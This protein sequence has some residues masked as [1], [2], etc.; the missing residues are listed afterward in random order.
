VQTNIATINN[1]TAG[2]DLSGQ[3]Y[4]YSGGV[5]DG[6][7][8]QTAAVTL[9]NTNS[10]VSVTIPGYG[11]NWANSNLLAYGIYGSSNCTLRFSRNYGY[12]ARII[13]YTV[14]GG[15]STTNYTAK[16]NGVNMTLSSGTV[17]IPDGKTN[18]DIS[19]SAINPLQNASNNITVTLTSGY[20]KINS[21][22]KTVSIGLMPDYPTVDVTA[23][24]L[25]MIR[26]D[27]TSSLIFY[28]ELYFTN[29]G[30]ART[31]HYTLA[32]S[33]CANDGSDFT[34]ILTNSVV[35]PAGASAVT[36]VLV[37]TVQ[38]Y[39]N[40]TKN[41]IVTLTSSS[42]YNIGGTNTV[43]I[44][45]EDDFPNVEVGASFTTM[46]RG[47][48][49]TSLIFQRDTWYPGISPALTVNY[50]LAGSTAI[51]GTDYTA[52]WPITSGSAYIPA[53]VNSVTYGLT[54]AAEAS[55]GGTKTLT[56][57]L[58]P[59][60][61]YNYGAS[62][63]YTVGI[64]EDAPL[65]I[66]SAS[67]PYAYQNVSNGMFSIS[68]TGGLPNSATAHYTVSG[69]AVAGINYTNL[70]SSVTFSPN[71]TTTN[72]TVGP[73]ASPL[74]TNAQ[75][76][77]LSL[78]SNSQYYLGATT[79]AVVTILPVSSSTNSVASPVGRY[80][81]GTGDDPTFWSIV[82]PQ[83]YEKGV[84]YDNENGNCST[85]YPN[86]TSWSTTNY[87]HY[88]ATNT[89]TQSNSANRIQFNN[90]IVAFG[91]RVGGTPLYLNQNYSFGIYAGDQEGSPIVINV[92]T[93]SNYSYV[94]AIN[95]SVPTNYTNLSQAFISNGFQATFTNYGLT[96]TL[97]TTPD[98]NWGE[99]DAGEEISAYVLT[100]SAS[101]AATNYYYV[102]QSVGWPEDFS[103]P[104][105]QD[106]NGT[107]SPSILYSL[108][109]EPYP[110][111]RATFIDQPHFDGNP[112]PP[113]YA[114]M[115]V[116]EMLTNTPPV[117]NAVSLAPS[118]CTNL[119]DS[120]ELRRHP[121]LDQ[122][123]ANLGN[124][125]IALANYVI[126]QID[127]TDAMDYNDNGNV[128][129]QSINLSG[130]TRGALGTYLEKQGS[131]L[132]QCAL[133]V[134][135]LRQAG[136]PAAYEY[137]PHNGLQILDARLSRMLKFQVQGGFSEAGQ[138]YTSNTM[139]AVNYP[140]VAAYIGTNWV[141]IFPWLK[142]YD[143]EEGFNLWDYMPAN[144]PNAYAW[145]HDYIYGNT[146]LLSLAVDGDNTPRVVFP[147][148]LKQTLLQNHPTISVSDIG[149]KVL[150]RQHYYARWS[151]FPTPTSLTNI[152]YTVESM[153][154]S[155]I[156][157]VDPLL[158]NVFDTLNI[159]V[160]SLTDPHKDIQTGPM[161]L[162]DLHNRQFY[163]TQTNNAPN[164]WQLNLILAP[165]RTNV[166]TQYAYTNDAALLSKEVLTTT[167]DQ[168][169]DQLRVRFQY[170]RH[171]AL[172]PSY[173]IDPWLPFMGFSAGEQ[174]IFER[175]L[176][177]GDLAAICLDY[178]RVT[179]DMLN[180][181]AQDIWQM[182]NKLRINPAL[183]NSISSDVYQGATMYLAG[184]S[185]FEKLSE[186]DV[187][188]AN[189]NKVV[190]LSTWA[191]G[192]S[193]LS[194]HR[195][196][197][198]NLY[199]GGVDPILPNVDMFLYW[200]AR[201]GNGTLRPD[202]GQ[203]MEEVFHNYAVMSIVDGSAQEHQVINTYY[204]QTNAVST[205]RLLQLSQ[206]Q[207]RGIV[208]FNYYNYAA[209]GTNLYQGKQLQSIDTGLWQQV[210]NAFQS[211]YGPWITGYITPGPITNAAYS[212][213]GVFIFEWSQWLALI[214]PQSLNGAFGENMP[215]GTISGG[216][217]PNYNL[218]MGDGSTPV[219]ALQP[220]AAGSDVLPD[221]VAIFNAPQTY[222]E[223]LNGTYTFDPVNMT[224]DNFVNTLLGLTPKS[225]PA[226]TTAQALSYIWDVGSLGNTS[227]AGA[228][229]LT[230]ASDP[231]NTI[232]GEFYVDETDLQLPGPIPLSLRRNYSSQNLADNQFGTGWKLS[233]MPYLSVGVGATNIYAADMDGAVLAYVQTSTNTWMPT[234]VA[235]P[236]L[237]NNTTA[238]VGGLVNRLRDRLVQTVNAGVTNYTLYGA[239]GSTRTFLVT[240][241]NDGVIN[242]VRPYL[243]QWTD[244]AGN[245]YTFTYE[246]DP[247]E[248]D[249][250][251]V[252]R[253][254]CSN[255]NY[256]GF[257]YDIYGHILDAYC[258]DGRWLYY[259]YNE[260]G[261]LTAV[262]LPDNTV[263]EYKYLLGTQAV[264]NGS[265][266]SQQPYS[267]HLLIEEDKPEGRVLQNAYD[268]QQ[269][270]TNQ[271]STT[272]SDLN[273]VRTATF[274]Y[275]NNF[276]LTNSPTNAITGTTWIV[277]GLNHTNRYDYANNLITLVTDP[278]GQTFQQIWCADNA[279]APG[280]PRS[281][282]QRKDKRGVW[283]QF[284]YD[285]NGNVTNSA[286]TGDLTGDGIP[287]Q[288]AISTAIYNTN[289]LPLQ[290][291]DPVGNSMVYVYDANFPFKPQ[292]V[293]RYAGATPVSTNFQVYS[294]VTNT[295]ILGFTTQTNMA[296]GVMT[297]QIRAYGS[298]DAATNDFTYDGHGFITQ[299]VR[300]TGTTDPNIVN[301]YFYNERGN[302]VVQMDSLGAYTFMEYDALDRPIEKE[303]FDESGHPLAW[304]LTYY[305][306]NGEISWTDG[307]RYNPEDYIFYDYD[308]AGRVT[309]ELHW[310]SQAKSDGTGVEAP[311]G[312]NLY[313]Q[314]FYQYD[315][316][317]NLLLKV[318]PRGA[319]ATNIWDA[320]SRLV[321]TKHLDVDSATVLSTEGYSYEPGGQVQTH[322]NALGGVATTFYTATGKPEIRYNADGSTNGWRYY[323]DG[324][325]NLEIQRNGAYWQTTYDD[326]NRITTRTFY[327]PTG[328]P[329]AANSTQLD[330]RGNVIQ[331]V[332]AGGNVFTNAFD[333]L[334]RPKVTAGPAIVTV[335][336]VLSGMNPGGPV[337]YETNVLQEAVTNFYDSA[338]RAVTN[339]NALGEQTITTMDALGR[340]TGNFV[341]SASASL[342]REKYFA[343][344]A[345]HNSV[346]VTDG[347]GPTA[348]KHT[349]Y[350]DND[351]HTV[352]SIAYPYT[353]CLDYTWRSYDLSGNLAYEEHDTSPGGEFTFAGYAHDGLN[354]VTS[355]TNRD[356]AVTFYTH[357][358]L[359]DL[360]SR[361]IPGGLQWKA[362]YNNAGQVQADW[363]AGSG[364][365]T[366]RSNS[367]TYY[368]G[369]NAFA[370]LR[371]TMT[372]GRGMVSTYSYDDWLRQASI[373]R[374]DLDYNH[375]DTFWTYDPRGYATNILEQNTGWVLGNGGNNPKVVSRAYDPYGQLSSETVTWNGRTVSTASQ[376]WDAAGRRTGLSLNDANYGYGWRAD[377]AMTYA[378]D[379][380][381]SGN[382]G[383]D[384]A[385]LLTNRVVGSRTTTVNDRDGEGRPYAITT[386]VNGANQLIELMEWY[387]DGK[388][389][390]D[391]YYEPTL[392]AGW[393]YS[394][395]ARSR[396]LTQ[397]EFSIEY[398]NF[399][400]TDWTDWLTYDNGV[401]AGPG[402]LTQ[403][404]DPNQNC[405]NWNGGVSPF[406]RVNTETNTSTGYS[407][408]G[409]VN[410]Q[411]SLTALLDGQ[412]VAVTTTGTNDAYAWSAQMQ[413]TPGTHQLVVKALNWSGFY[414]ASATS[415]FTNKMGYETAAITRDYDGNIIQRTW[416]DTNGTMLH[417]QKLYFDVKNHLTDIIDADGANNGFVWH[418]EYDGLDRR[419]V[420]EYYVMTN[421][422]I[423]ITPQTIYQY[424]D[425]NVEFLE[426][427]VSVDN[428]TTWK[429]YGPDL[430][431][432]Y[433][434]LNGTGGLDGVS[435]YLNEFN[436]V[437]S[438]SRGNILAEVTNGIVSW[439]SAR[440]TGYGF[441][442]GYQPIALGHG[443]DLAQA[444]AWR[445]RW[446][447]ATGHYQ[448]G[449]RPY[450]PVAGN[451]LSYDSIFD[452]RDPNGLSAFGGDPINYFDADG[453]CPEGQ[454]QSA[455]WQTYGGPIGNETLADVAARLGLSGGLAATPWAIANA[456]GNVGMFTPNISYAT[457]PTDSG[458]GGQ[459]FMD[460]AVNLGAMQQD[461]SYLGNSDFR[462]GWG[463]AIGVT[464]GVKLGA[465]V[466]GA[467]GNIV[468]IG[469][470]GA[471]KTGIQ[472]GLT[473]LT[474]TGVKSLTEAGATATAN[475]SFYSAAYEMA[476]DA[477]DLGKSRPVQFNRANAALDAAMQ[478]DSEFAAQMEELIPGVGDS[479]SSVGGRATP[480]GWIW[481]H[482][483]DTGIMQLVPEA[484]HTPGSIFWDTLHPGGKGGYSTWAIPAGAPP[485]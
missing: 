245:F 26:G 142:D 173:P 473:G 337:T 20:Y 243:Q 434:G 400:G 252:I 78:S 107:N 273:P 401:A 431:G 324:R 210:S 335:N 226:Q 289:S 471:I 90:P 394:Y 227:D 302:P 101:S 30:T 53:G 241:F 375:V 88:N 231:V 157:N 102:V 242:Q 126:N 279:T 46:T 220:P 343:Y 443:A 395:A 458:W 372:D 483:E 139:I 154:D 313:A 106:I 133:L 168:F 278:L 239:D 355:M 11:N 169:D 457:P 429:L 461:L 272:G 315:V 147:A 299:A 50:T 450:D 99:V 119:D 319:M 437:I 192:L 213:M 412:P 207:G 310:R 205:V 427:G 178:G 105:A 165:F 177:K 188:N 342:V 103:T 136:V 280:Y 49:T 304:N 29:S 206:N 97:S 316:L 25:G 463:V 62:S 314:T 64:L 323:L 63:N 55:L 300:Y 447:D 22:A 470:I 233:I 89:L 381:G 218:N 269:R 329:E 240:N 449:L 31:V 143:L 37:P 476:L 113:F 334:D 9:L 174:A 176:R 33:T 361:I 72:L 219:M 413:L 441:M 123:V 318:D 456:S 182:E 54:P 474:E 59:G 65:F 112:L 181:H 430:N 277:D 191:A 201:T 124:D 98:L 311:S 184:M 67:S 309:S 290:L 200:M 284:Q 271:M 417:Q 96:T 306:D 348:I 428:Q 209:L 465:D 292:Q 129:E 291:T 426:L 198:G 163:V 267:T 85:L 362:V 193:K 264:T 217:T 276:N 44:A 83:D 258:G 298:S 283:T 452:P 274:I 202:S 297:R 80:W 91:E 484:Q 462:S 7:L 211:G 160:Y 402:V 166:T 150:N 216:N 350:T 87:Y 415:T 58:Q 164:Q 109:F 183:S 156:T 359:G 448:I 60:Y 23:T 232:T 287:T 408:Y 221:E 229:A 387:G 195:D 249:F 230:R 418:A 108:E 137:A 152:C 446:M 360:T 442:P 32:G 364:G 444:C 6:L 117:T 40:P 303:N 256:L 56:I 365:V 2:W 436:P 322:T 383:F 69:T 254:Q 423:S 293:I 3:F 377:G 266:V 286:V 369:G 18:I 312:Y 356:N 36:N 468:S 140:W 407:A 317:G 275:S 419:L 175:P 81:R 440:P 459:G 185:Y 403:M 149:M 406:S 340:T 47:E 390:W 455:P 214:S 95:L 71:Q 12:S 196:S 259:D 225:T 158:T 132:E 42:G 398:N 180:V 411:S 179:R 34:P 466:I 288:T 435:P 61:R 385:G 481:H 161:R 321:Q 485:N 296:F 396:R 8:A 380:T 327:S 138:L 472:N 251:Q 131:P 27:T 141:H 122:F 17:T 376:N 186:F 451:W 84:V 393:N 410:G 111:W 347:S 151:D 234:S 224:F 146:N 16:T 170:Y 301:T 110:P 404:G 208:P 128:A 250:G 282:S 118:A 14:T 464:A 344:S 382:Y 454:N 35:I 74:L 19:I 392:S 345:D 223:I 248:P 332:D 336:S 52:T 94:G 261:D 262:T 263:R 212:G 51:N 326:V 237:N 469:E 104:M 48:S 115:T 307:P 475:G 373:T 391:T 79:Q 478:A 421:G 159:E 43:T 153:S 86:L 439:N 331:T 265:T 21:A 228:Q 130:I 330:R 384:T 189:L 82:I 386:S 432:K 357:D 480:E 15:A 453:R 171:R 320:L 281:V 374:T 366:T 346:T 148:Y 305:T 325:I 70:P 68:R 1:G 121:I 204:G 352:L 92:Y 414:T 199:N 339:I 76:V 389:M 134:Y 246:T 482:A 100:H 4:I 438:D 155:S 39:S 260:Y 145:T 405:A 215:D 295:V 57:T 379:P 368:P 235:N 445:G 268:S 238:G 75:T 162:V 10:I 388:Q 416:S 285:S 294:S 127:L 255:G 363:L 367:Y 93:R 433:G 477:L 144:Y 45:D 399:S 270:V 308:G 77:V 333:G 424:Y 353:G 187:T 135:L 172:S 203:T 236:K 467:V 28:R 120:P 253:I 338:G 479:V 397:E 370:G 194:P 66:V 247:T 167:L 73:T 13:N 24:S 349:T 378:A 351:G 425:P 358:P 371:D 222:S 257:D 41:L 197:S 460:V 116:A 114:G 420:T 354:R 125:P 5:V 38:P 190:N 409:Q 328:V 422:N 341:Y 244:S